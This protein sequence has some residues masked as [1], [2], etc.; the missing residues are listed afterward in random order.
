MSD[1]S[2]HY[3]IED[4]LAAERG[5]LAQVVF[6]VLVVYLEAV[7]HTERKTLRLK[8][9]KRNSKNKKIT[10]KIQQTRFC[11]RDHH[12]VWRI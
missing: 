3:F 9:I 12:L 2:Q 6:V 8:R 4:S 11:T 1:A 7:R 10:D 5:A